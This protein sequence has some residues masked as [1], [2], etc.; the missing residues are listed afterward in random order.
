MLLPAW[1]VLP[2]RAHR[3]GFCHSSLS[4][5]FTFLEKS[6]L[7]NLANPSSPR[8][9]YS[10]FITLITMWILSYIYISAIM[11]AAQFG[12]FTAVSLTHR[13]THSMCSINVYW[14]SSQFLVILVEMCSCIYGYEIR[15]IWFAIRNTQHRV[16]YWIQRKGE[17]RPC[18]WFPKIWEGRKFTEAH[19]PHLMG[20]LSK[21]KGRTSKVVKFFPMSVTDEAA[22]PSLPPPIL[23]SLSIASILHYAAYVQ[24]WKIIYMCEN[25]P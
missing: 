19:L 6:S 1:N 12:I 11:T 25:F 5:K 13:R 20:G 21:R 16:S 2:P 18:R 23:P 22:L 10:F 4:L 3:A 7:A 15:K 24:G 14:Q 8:K 17:Y 9:L